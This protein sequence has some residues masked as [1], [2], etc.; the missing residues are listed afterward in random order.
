MAYQL[1]E[2]IKQESRIRKCKD[3][4]NVNHTH[5]RSSF[6]KNKS[7]GRNIGK[8]TKK[9]LLKGPTTKQKEKLVIKNILFYE[10]TWYF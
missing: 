4:K 3:T 10:S 1:H 8:K 6:K 2:T 9:W 5:Q 7:G